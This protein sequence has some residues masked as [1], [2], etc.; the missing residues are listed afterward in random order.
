ML[1]LIPIVKNDYLLT[2][3]YAIVIILSFVLG[4]ERRD[5]LFLIVGLIV[6]F[7]GEFFFLKTNVETFNRT[8][9]IGIMPLWLPV[10]WAYIFVAI[11]R[12]IKILK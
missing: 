10:I 3:I 12:I 11:K 2:L 4:Y 6:M 7:L 5:I 1:V 8:S 9:L